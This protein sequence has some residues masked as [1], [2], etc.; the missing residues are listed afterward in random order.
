MTLAVTIFGNGTSWYNAR[1]VT[2][3][4]TTIFAVYELF[5]RCVAMHVCINM[6]VCVS[7]TAVVSDGHQE[8]TLGVG[9]SQPANQ[10]SS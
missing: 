6:C 4:D 10:R 1:A 9:L 5:H 8:L 2:R 3:H 7:A